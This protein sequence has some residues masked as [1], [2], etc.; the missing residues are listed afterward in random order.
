MDNYLILHIDI[1]F[2]AGIV[3]TGNGRSHPIKNGNEELLWLYFFNDPRQNKV[4]FG[5]DNKKHYNNLELNYFGDFFNQIT[6][7]NLKFNVR[8]TLRPILELIEN[9]GLLELLRNKYKEVTLDVEEKIPTLITFSSS[10]SNSAKQ[11]MVEFLASRNFNIESYTIPLAELISFYYLKE[12]KISASHGKSILF[13]KATNTALHLMK[14]NFTDGYFL[15]EETTSLIYKGKGYDPRKKSIVKLVV[16]EVNTATGVLSSSDEIEKECERFESIAEDWL[17][18]IDASSGNRPIFIRAISLSLAPYMFKDILV[19]REDIENDTGYYIQELID[20]YNA[21]ESDHI[22][23]KASIASVILFGN[24]F[25]NSLIKKKFENQ[26][27]QEKLIIATTNKLLEILSVYPSIDI[28]RYSDTEAR[29]KALA[30]AESEAKAQQS[31]MEYKRK[32]DE[33]EKLKKIEDS[34]KIEKNKRI[35]KDLFDKAIRLEAENNLLDAIANLENARELDP[36]NEEILLLYKTLKEKKIELEM[37]TKQYKK[38]L[39]EGEKLNASGD[40]N[41]ALNKFELAKSIIDSPEIRTTI[42]ELKSKIKEQIN[43]RKVAVQHYNSARQYFD[44]MK[45]AESKSEIEASLK[46]DETNIDANQLLNNINK[47][48]LKQEKEFNELRENADNLFKKKNLN[49]ATDEYKRAL[50]IFPGDLYCLNKLDGIKQIQEL[51]SNMKKEFQNIIKIADQFYEENQCGRALQEYEKAKILFPDDKYVEDKIEKL[52]FIRLEEQRELSKKLRT[53]NN[54][55]NT[56]DYLKANELFEELIKLIPEDKAIQDKLKVLKI[57]LA[58]GDTAY[59]NN[60]PEESKPDDWNFGSS[61]SGH[62][63]N[64]KE[65]KTGTDD[66]LDKHKRPSSVDTTKTLPSKKKFDF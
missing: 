2:I 10:I 34:K 43:I 7:D 61:Q 38:L 64:N 25:N 23:E 14:L 36:D 54:Y 9:S 20:I 22:T 33:D 26:I 42:I 63:K 13:L 28:R 30:Q 50:V 18:R 59:D 5:K 40:L 8:G 37:V 12:D 4:T 46:L 1:E 53:A 21:F 57:K 11:L 55:F 16:N 66:F 24:C 52:K 15:K 29:I 31:A 35:A 44:E 62:L 65:P 3:Y 60:N 17:K 6:E 27:D 39:S 56:K 45:F 49:E 19:R 41:E 58:F 51:A 47:V 48:I 32:K